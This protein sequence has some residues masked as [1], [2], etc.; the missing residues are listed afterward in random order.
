[1]DDKSVVTNKEPQQAWSIPQGKSFLD[2]F[3]GT[4]GNGVGWPKLTDAWF[5]STRNMCIRFQVKGSCTQRC[6]LAHTVKSK[7]SGTQE[8]KASAKFRK[9]H[10]K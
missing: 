8:T 6:T 1:M 10:G 7:M 2:F 9:I 5:E 4:Q 3:N